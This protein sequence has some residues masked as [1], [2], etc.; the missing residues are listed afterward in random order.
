MRSGDFRRRL[1]GGVGLDARYGGEGWR[2]LEGDMEGGLRKRGEDADD[3]ES[4]ICG[5]A[6]VERIAGIGDGDA[7]WDG[8]TTLN[9]EGTMLEIGVDSSLVGIQ[10]ETEKEEEEEENQYVVNGRKVLDLLDDWIGVRL[11]LGL[12]LGHGS[13]TTLLV[14]PNRHR[15]MRAQKRRN[16]MVGG[17]RFLSKKEAFSRRQF[18]TQVFALAEDLEQLSESHVY[19]LPTVLLSVKVLCCTLDGLLTQLC[20]A[21]ELD[22]GLGRPM[23]SNLLG[24]GMDG[25]SPSAQVL[26]DFLRLERGWCPYYLR[27]MAMENDYAAL[28]YSSRFGRGMPVDS[29]HKDCS[30]S[31]CLVDS[32]EAQGHMS[33]HVRDRCQCRTILPNQQKIREI[34]LSGG[35]PILQVKGE[36]KRGLGI[37]VK[38]LDSRMRFVAVSHAGAG[39][40]TN[41]IMYECRLRQIQGYLDGRSGAKSRH[42]RQTG[43][44]ASLEGKNGRQDQRTTTQYFWLDTLCLPTA[45]EG[46]VFDEARSEAINKLQAVYTLADRVLVLDPAMERTSLEHTP[47]CERLAALAVSPWINSVSALSATILARRW[48]VQC[49]D[50]TFDPFASPETAADE[51]RRKGGR[52]GKGSRWLPKRITSENL[53]AAPKKNASLLISDSLAHQFQQTLNQRFNNMDIGTTDTSESFV[54]VWNHMADSLPTEPTNAIATLSSLLPYNTQP[55][56]R[57]STT[58]ERLSVII[59]TLNAIPL[60]LFFNQHLPRQKPL[61]N[62]RNRWMPSWVPSSQNDRLIPLLPETD[63]RVGGDGELYLSNT[64]ASRKEVEVLVCIDMPKETDMDVAGWGTVKVRNAEDGMVWEV[65]VLREDWEKDEMATDERGVFCFVFIRPDEAEIGETCQ[66]ALFRVRKV[67]TS[68]KGDGKG[69]YS[70]GYGF[71]K[72]SLYQDGFESGGVSPEGAHVSM[73]FSDKQVNKLMPDAEDLRL[74][75]ASHHV[76]GIIQTVYDCPVTL[77]PLQ[78][79]DPKQLVEASESDRSTP[80]PPLLTAIPLP[81]SWKMLIEKEPHSPS[82]SGPQTLATRPPLTDVTLP[83]TLTTHFLLTAL[84]G[85]LASSC[86]GFTLGIIGTS[87]PFLPM[88]ANAALIG[89]LGLHCLFVI[90]MFW[91]DAMADDDD[92]DDANSQSRRRRWANRWKKGT[93]AQR[94]GIWQATQ[95]RLHGLN[96]SIGGATWDVLH[97]AMVVLYTVALVLPIDGRKRTPRALDKAFIGWS[98]LGHLFSMMVKLVVREYVLG[99]L[100]L[101]RYLASFEDE[102]AAVHG[103]SRQSFQWNEKGA[104]MVE[105][106]QVDEGLHVQEENEQVHDVRNLLPSQRTRDQLFSQLPSQRRQQTQPQ[107]QPQPQIYGHRQEEDDMMV[108]EEWSRAR[109]QE[110]QLPREQPPEEDKRNEQEKRISRR[111]RLFGGMLRRTKALRL[112]PDKDTKNSKKKRSKS[113]KRPSRDDPDNFSTVATIGYGDD[114]DDYEDGAHDGDQ[115]RSTEVCLLAELE[116]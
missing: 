28:Y 71:N 63:V 69:K 105:V 16:A 21:L 65:N 52:S 93:D 67:N 47:L 108:Y 30:E 40:G 62:H 32:G 29:E 23:L 9:G 86:V 43:G 70:D 33:K 77:M 57:L 95:G 48:E 56:L 66:G 79:D 5:E 31:K 97:I 72:D 74:A 96:L 113:K 12:G 64:K 109:G 115:G 8:G 34:L 107:P 51:E 87:F 42:R 94:G 50:G 3:A 7:G 104:L 98:I 53:S 35:I 114:R 13:S 91:V 59:S 73:S 83:P 6:D 116:G 25:P 92:D 4:R 55:L 76:E 38:Q 1:L 84:D 54:A 112:K 20:P 68:S 110:R 106:R 101:D 41:N 22:G 88:I 90:C 11:G 82:D 102:S 17:K 80:Q 18:L 61:A 39:A 14:G 81:L 24:S 58:S 85:L 49:A 19:P 46:G 100:L 89:K 44:Y 37:K 2:E 111:E 103:Q 45:G 15:L 60:S 27:K 78:E 99:P 26:L 36:P 10:E 75:L